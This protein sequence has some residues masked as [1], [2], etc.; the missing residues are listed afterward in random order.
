MVTFIYLVIPQTIRVDRGTETDLMTT[1][2][3]YLHQLHDTYD[4]LDQLIQNCVMYGPSTANKIERWWRELHHRMETYFKE[5]LHQLLEN[6]YYDQ[7]NQL[8]R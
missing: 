4:D 6:G 3:C 5:Q 7:T 1:A 8:D 2:H